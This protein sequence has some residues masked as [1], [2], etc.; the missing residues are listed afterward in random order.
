MI[1]GNCLSTFLTGSG[2]EID[3]IDDIQICNKFHQVARQMR[4]RHN[5][6]STLDINDEYDVQDLLSVI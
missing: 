6:R 2:L 4:S 5:N 3:D 1:T